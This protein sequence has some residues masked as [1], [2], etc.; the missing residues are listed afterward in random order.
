MSGEY[1]V[2]TYRLETP[3]EVE[4]VAEKMLGELGGGSD[5]KG[6][7]G[8]HLA[9]EFSA[10]VTAFRPLSPASSAALRGRFPA[11]TPMWNRAEVDVAI[12]LAATGVGLLN[13]VAALLG[14]VFELSQVSALRLLDFTVP[15]ELELTTPGPAF[16]IDGT[17]WLAGVEDRP[18]IGSIVKP[19]VGLTPA[20]TAQLVEALALG[21]IDFVKDDELMSSPSTSP[22][23]V[24]VREVSQAIDAVAE[25][26]GRKVMFAFNIS[27]D[28]PDTIRRNHDAV[29]EAGGTCVMVSL[30]QVGLAAFLQ[31]R[32][33]CELPIHGHR[34]GWGMLT[35]APGLG[36]DFRAYQRIWRLAGVDQLHCNG[37]S[38][39]FFEPDESVARSIEACLEPSPNHCN[40]L[41]VLSSGQWGG[42]APVTYDR[43]GTTD[44]LY[45]AGGGIQGHPGGPA[46]GIAAVRASW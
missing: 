3:Y 13:V 1:I 6:R 41:P 29:V 14:N 10:E 20:E 31:L 2:A 17:R 45:L 46:A 40:V 12:P 15:E 21:G 24:R 35:R 9:P 22:L 42:Q 27:S 44:L 30:N 8:R 36:L 19:S 34:N 16:G 11:A 4:R 39:K 32:R 25:Q 26:T 43:T 23:T 18:L 33:C 7:D 5:D 38:N 37:F 28:N